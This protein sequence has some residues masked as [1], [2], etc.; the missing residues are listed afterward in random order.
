MNS[1][2][3]KI[4]L[5]VFESDSF[6]QAAKKLYMS[7]QGVAKIINRLENEL[8][9]ELFHRSKQGI[10]PTKY[11]IKLYHKSQELNQILNDI[12]YIKDNH[13]DYKNLNIYTTYGLLQKLEFNFFNKFQLQY[14]HIHLNIIEYPDVALNM[15]FDL[16]RVHIGFM[17]SPIDTRKYNS[18]YFT[19][20]YFKL[21]IKKDNPLALKS[22]I[23]LSDIVEY[24]FAIKGKDYKIFD[25]NMGH[26]L[27]AQLIPRISFQCSQDSYLLD[28]VIERNGVSIMLE[29]SINYLINHCPKYNNEII[30]K[31][32]QD[33]IFK[34]DIYYV[35]KTMLNFLLKN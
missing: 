27:K 26:F 28:Y 35:E 1:Q 12:H 24:P 5:T 6:N 30:I 29:S 4:F 13:D 8:D 9:I 15:L 14:P 3:L 19:S 34:R 22:Q 32:I 20:D 2:D 21:I 18:Y 17:N 11:G 31:D 10:T 23:N 16:N 25:M 33:S 7:S